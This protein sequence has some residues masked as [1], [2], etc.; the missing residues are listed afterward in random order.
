MSLTLNT[1]DYSCCAQLRFQRPVHVCVSIRCYCL[2]LG[3]CFATTAVNSQAGL[4][5]DPGQ[6]FD[7]HLEHR[8]GR[9]P[10]IPARWGWYDVSWGDAGRRT[11]RWRQA[12][13]IVYTH[14]QELREEWFLQRSAWTLDTDERRGYGLFEEKKSSRLNNSFSLRIPL[15][16]SYTVSHITA[17]KSLLAQI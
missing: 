1:Y 14:A 5:D 16:H 7:V 17:N 2:Y 11:H 8:L 10:G 9:F 13:L 12:H 6:G 15:W 3:P 4:W